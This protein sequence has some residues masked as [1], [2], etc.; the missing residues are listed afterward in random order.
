LS[1]QDRWI[2]YCNKLNEDKVESIVGSTNMDI[3]NEYYDKYNIPKRRLSL[4]W[5]QRSVDTFLGLPFNIAS[6]GL[7]LHMLAQ[8]TNM[9]AGTLIGDLTNVH[10]YQNH[11]EQCKEQIGREPLSLP[12]LK[13]EKAKDIFSY[14]YGDVKID[15]YVSHEP[16]K[17]DISV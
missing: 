10:I 17:G 5:H 11:I 13:L 1:N 6:Y 14:C 4:K 8:Q 12:R 7:L 16:I 3:M 2:L 15:G 9:V